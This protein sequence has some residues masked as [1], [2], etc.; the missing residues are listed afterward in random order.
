MVGWKLNWVKGPILQT[1]QYKH[2][3]NKIGQLIVT[4]FHT[5]DTTNGIWE[6][7]QVETS[8]SPLSR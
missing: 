5:K 8:L 4:L 1:Q 6:M 2:I 7:C 3:N